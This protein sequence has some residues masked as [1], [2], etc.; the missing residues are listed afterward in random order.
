MRSCFGVRARV[1][2]RIHDSGTRQRAASSAASIN[3]GSLVPVR[4][5]HQLDICRF[6]R[7]SF[8]HLEVSSGCQNRCSVREL[9]SAGNTEGSA[10]PQGGVRYASFW[11]RP[12]NDIAI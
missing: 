3:S 5:G 12:K 10:S 8:N 1:R 9:D 2:L 11:P 4:S 7:H 6:C